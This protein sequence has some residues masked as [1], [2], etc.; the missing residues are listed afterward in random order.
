MIVP[1]DVSV[2]VVYVSPDQDQTSV[3][4]EEA[5]TA[6]EETGAHGVQ[7]RE[8]VDFERKTVW[9]PPLV[10]MSGPSINSRYHALF[11]GGTAFS[12]FGSVAVFFGFF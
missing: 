6:I 4:Y 9:H 8:R 5:L 10:L 11:G 1:R 3:A 2:G 12:P 7:C